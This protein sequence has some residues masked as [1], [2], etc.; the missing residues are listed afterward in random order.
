MKNVNVL[1]DM[2]CPNC[3]VAITL[4]AECLSCTSCERNYLID[5]GVPVF[6]ERGDQKD[7]EEMQGLV[8]QIESNPERIVN[9][10]DIF[11][12]PNRPNSAARLKSEE[13]SFRFFDKN[14]SNLQNKRILNISCGIGRE[15]SILLEKGVVDITILDISR[16]AVLYADKNLRLIY[17]FVH[18][19]SVI[20]DAVLLPFKQ[21]EFDVVFVYGSAHHYEDFCKFLVQAMRVSSELYILSEPA[22][23]GGVQWVFDRLGWNTEYGEID[24]H[25]LYDNRILSMCDTLGFNVEIEKNSQYFPKALDFI[26]DNKLGIALWFGFLNVLDLVLP[27]SM[28]HSINLRITKVKH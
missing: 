14:I 21:K 24:T 27:K 22:H 11:R 28:R 6:T 18:I 13:K 4:E 15:A 16:P 5:D 12:L 25:R 26:G 20:S 23:M 7:L 3:F 19:R 17:P 1:D 8:E 10:R 2:V 9:D